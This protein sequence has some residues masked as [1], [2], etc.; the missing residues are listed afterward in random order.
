M[1][2]IALQT[3]VRRTAHPSRLG[4]GPSLRAVL[5]ADSLPLGSLLPGLLLP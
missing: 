3:V 2:P 5:L 4:R 1:S